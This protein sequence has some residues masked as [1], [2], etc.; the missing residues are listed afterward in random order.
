MKWQELLKK[1]LALLLVAGFA[2]LTAPASHAGNIQVTTADQIGVACFG[3]WELINSDGDPAHSAPGVLLGWQNSATNIVSASGIYTIRFGAIPGYTKPADITG[4]DFAGANTYTFANGALYFRDTNSGTGAGF[5]NRTKTLKVNITPDIAT[6]FDVGPVG[7]TWSLDGGLVRFPSGATV[8]APTSYK[9]T[10][11][12]A[13]SG[14]WKKPHA[15]TGTFTNSA[16]NTANGVTGSGTPSAPYVITRPYTHVPSDFD[17]NGRSDVLF[18]NATDGLLYDWEINAQNSSGY[19]TFTVGTAGYVTQDPAGSTLVAQADFNGDGQ[20]DLLFQDNTTRNLTVWVMDGAQGTAHVSH[21]NSITYTLAANTFVGGAADFNGDGLADI[22]AVDHSGSTMVPTVLTFTHHDFA[23]N[24][25]SQG[26]TTGTF[27]TLTTVPTASAAKKADGVTALTIP[28][29]GATAYSSTTGWH[30]AALADIDGDG[31]AD[32]VWRS[33]NS[34]QVSIWNMKGTNGNVRKS[35]GNLSPAL[36]A[37]N[38]TTGTG[39]HISGTG[40]FNGDGYTDLLLRNGTTGEVA[41]WLLK[42]QPT[43]SVVSKVANG[44]NTAV[45]FPTAV[46]PNPTAADTTRGSGSIVDADGA[47]IKAGTFTASTG[48]SVQ[49]V[50]EFGTGGSTYSNTNGNDVVWRYMGTGHTYV[51]QFH[52]RT[53]VGYG[54][55]SVYP[56]AIATWTV[57]PMRT[58]PT[59][60]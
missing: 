27:T 1:R 5:T 22:L 51:M 58:V 35:L 55:T 38:N 20:A 29:T 25:I 6:V 13:T 37:F 19:Q 44:T 47:A 14:N 56:G 46:A 50:G 9:I 43:G 34:G 48:W 41:V 3:Q 24:S 45:L 60:H 54:F 23:C 40:D 26:C 2:L 52:G 31:F 39:W 57:Q 36:G 15:I 7:A 28:N 12:D 42:G 33:M 30:T 59:A 10:F 4:V 53:V 8:S 21:A 32:I 18:R 16:S 49:G 17:D 11:Y